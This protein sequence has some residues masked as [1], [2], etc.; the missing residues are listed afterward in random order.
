MRCNLGAMED[1]FHALWRCPSVN[2]IWKI[3]GFKNII[4]NYLDREPLCFLNWVREKFPINDFNVLCTLSRQIWQ[5]RN[6]VLHNI[7]IPQDAFAV[8]WC[9]SFLQE[10]DKCSAK[11]VQPNPRQRAK[12]K[13]PDSDFLKI[14]VD[15]ATNS[16]KNGVG[17]GVVMRDHNGSVIASRMAFKNYCFGALAAELVAIKEGLI[18]AL[19]LN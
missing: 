15:A 11:L 7:A 5:L 19:I 2:K 6:K 14:N 16:E 10:F 18:F 3:A 8:D 12:W 17:H 13:P 4:S 9:I 1:I